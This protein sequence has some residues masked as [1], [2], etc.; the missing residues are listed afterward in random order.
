M[1]RP[2]TDLIEHLKKYN[3]AVMIVGSKTLQRVLPEK[4]QDDPDFIKK[5]PLF[6]QPGESSMNI[7]S[8]KTMIKSPDMFWKFYEQMIMKDPEESTNTYNKIKELVDMKLIKSVID[9][10][11]DGTLSNIKSEYIPMRGNRNILQCVKCGKT[12]NTSDINLDVSKPILCCDYNDE[13][14]KGKIKPTIPFYGEKYCTEDTSRVFHDIFTYDED[15][16]PI[17]LNTHTLILI[18]PNFAEDLLDEIITGF[19]QFRPQQ[20]DTFSVFITDNDDM[21]MNDYLAD[22]GTTYDIEESLTKLINMLKN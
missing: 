7:F 13:L 16:K 17:G 20:P 6:F 18:G 15:D 10:N 5:E 2:I 4:E 3:D 11:T 8:R 22:F 19:N 12:F 9:F 14:C 21:Y 1:K